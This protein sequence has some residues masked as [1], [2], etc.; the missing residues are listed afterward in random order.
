[1]RYTE[2]LIKSR[3]PFQIK[4][5]YRFLQSLCE[6][7]AINNTD[8]RFWSFKWPLGT[9]KTGS[10][11]DLA[12]Q[13]MLSVW[14]KK[15]HKNSETKQNAPPNKNKQSY[16]KYCGYV[17]GKRSMAEV[18]VSARSKVKWKGKKIL[19]DYTPSPCISHWRLFPLEI[20]PGRKALH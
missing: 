17:W 16:N 4:I 18:N 7:V 20:W 19:S 1:M 6:S 2:F 14:L 5:K 11:G 3:L 8:I 15:T 9:I 10:T 12:P 13:H